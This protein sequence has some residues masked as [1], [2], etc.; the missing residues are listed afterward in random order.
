MRENGFQPDFPPAVL[1]EIAEIARH[2]PAA[3][4]SN[5]VKDLR[6]KLWSSIDNDDSRDLDQIEFAE[7]LGDGRTKVMIGIA[8]VD[9]FVRKGSAIDGYAS[10]ETTS[11][12]TG[13]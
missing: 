6:E 4:P 7:A 11:V 9:H 10:S 12:Y 3:A 2:P 13:V 1:N 5:G 8:D